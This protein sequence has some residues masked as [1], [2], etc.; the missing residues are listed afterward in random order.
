MPFLIGNN[1]RSVGGSEQLFNKKMNNTKKKI[2][3]ICTN[4]FLF[5]AGSFDCMAQNEKERLLKQIAET[6]AE[7]ARLQQKDSKKSEQTYC[8]EK[9]VYNEVQP[10]STEEFEAFCKKEIPKVHNKPIE[11][12][13]AIY[14][15]CKQTPKGVQ[16]NFC[17]TTTPNVVNDTPTDGSAEKEKALL[18]IQNTKKMYEDLIESLNKELKNN[19]IEIVDQSI[20]LGVKHLE[21]DGPT[22]DLVKDNMTGL[23][24]NMVV[25]LREKYGL[26]EYKIKNENAQLIDD[27]ANQAES[28]LS[29]IPGGS[30]ITNHY[31]WRIFKSTP[32]LGKMIGHAG[33]MI[34]IFFQID[35]FQKKLEQLEKE[36]SLLLI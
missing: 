6:E 4:I 34:N 31:L 22:G 25:Q 32:E 10:M 14:S 17:I 9:V 18:K 15:S 36:E 27:L 16:A 21:I 1:K 28:L 29:I 30:K 5:C 13:Y 7:I 33:A 20:N 11:G 26:D 35:E 19:G 3:I 8:F 23:K 12:N 24:D 2:V